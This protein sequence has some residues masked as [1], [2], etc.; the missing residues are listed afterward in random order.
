MNI[1]FDSCEEAIAYLDK[2]QFHGFRLGLERIKA[3]LSALGEPQEAFPCI[4]VAGTNGKGSVCAAL[5]HIFTRAGFRTGFYSSPHLFSLNERFRVDMKPVEDSHLTGLIS[6]IATLVE[7]GFELS[8]FE[9]TTA[10]AFLYFARIG[11]DIA[12]V[13]TGL[14]GR[15]DATNVITPEVSVITNVSLEHQAY[16]GATIKE[17]AREK[18]GI[19]K[20]TVP[21]I[22]GSL[23]QQAEGVVMERAAE[24]E[25]PV[26]RLGREFRIHPGREGTFDYSGPFFR[27]RGLRFGLA[28]EH[29]LENA[30]TAI[31]AVETMNEREVDVPEEAVRSGLAETDW[32]ARGEFLRKGG[33]TV[34][35]DGAH[36]L[37]GVNALKGLLHNNNVQKESSRSD[38]ALLWACSDEGGDK[39]VSSLLERIAP[40]FGRIV[41]TEPPGPRKPVR[42]EDWQGKHPDGWKVCFESDWLK[43]LDLLVKEIQGHFLLVVS[44][45]LYLVGAVRDALLK[46]GFKKANMED[47]A[48]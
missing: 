33:V 4:H 30:A 44:G 3:V 5:S 19:I 15:L 18:A 38:R 32:P 26:L 43:A 21:V 37:A 46:M 14:G 7:E 16:L 2:F 28:G 9:F 47:L 40:F 41:I 10:M 36:N 39:D 45:S 25:C 8:Y 17:I 6:D 29:Q 31:S 42:I 27:M 12:V 24:L 23:D 22:T 34:L 20:R 13:E 11:V 1:Q 48:I 35:L